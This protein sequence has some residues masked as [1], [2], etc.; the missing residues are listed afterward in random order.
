MG[1]VYDFSAYNSY[2]TP[3]SYENYGVEAKADPDSQYGKAWTFNAW[4]RS[5][6]TPHLSSD[7]LDHVMD[8]PVNADTYKNASGNVNSFEADATATL[9]K[10]AVMDLT[11]CANPGG[12][13]T[14]L[15]YAGAVISASEFATD[16]QWHIYKL[17]NYTMP[18]SLGNHV[19]FNWAA[20]TVI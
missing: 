2:N 18:A 10:T 9:G 19:E 16:N 13:V 5:N 14:S 7:G 15:N 17:A 8:V 6:N 11:K 4:H 3:G 12:A 1:N 20:S